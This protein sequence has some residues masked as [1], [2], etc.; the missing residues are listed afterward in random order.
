MKLFQALSLRAKILIFLILIPVTCLLG[1]LRLSTNIFKAD[2]INSVFSSS[3]EQTETLSEHL[4]D[5]FSSMTRIS[6]L[7][8]QSYLN[9]GGKPQELS[10]ILYGALVGVQPSR[11]SRKPIDR[12]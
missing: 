2:K 4:S 3:R 10:K 5:R 1:F 7:L 12:S 8:F 6:R 11:E 9:A